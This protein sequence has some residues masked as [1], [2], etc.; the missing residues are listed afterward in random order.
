MKKKFL[1]MVLA[2]VMCLSL[3]ACGSKEETSNTSNAVVENESVAKAET[4]ES[5][6]APVE[7]VEQTTEVVTEEAQT[8][9]ETETAT[10]ESTEP[11][12]EVVPTWFEEHGLTLTPAG[13]FSFN[14]MSF[15]QYNSGRIEEQGT[16]EVL[17]TVT[18]EETTDGVD[19]G[20][21]VVKVTA[22]YDKSNVP[23]EEAGKYSWIW[24]STAFDKY[25]GTV[26]K[27][28]GVETNAENPTSLSE[29]NQT[30]VVG[31]I[32]YNVSAT[33]YGKSTEQTFTEILTFVVPVDYDGI[34]FGV[35]YCD[36]TMEY[37]EVETHDLEVS[38]GKEMYYFGIN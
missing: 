21:K 26:F 38:F 34:V 32:T 19:E 5:T 12:E 22:V 33:H 30:I 23:G 18:F 14:T 10:A 13:A 6:Q 11:V 36:T 15:I 3:C 1:A 2:S 35:G 31:D 25:T 9:V 37:V 7:T 20:Y 24:S 27:V 4:V 28:E 16:F 29:N 8:V 17:A